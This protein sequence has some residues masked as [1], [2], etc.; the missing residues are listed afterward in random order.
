MLTGFA[1]ITALSN[2]AIQTVVTDVHRAR[3][4]Y[5]EKM[6]LLSIWEATPP[7]NKYFILGHYIH[8]TNDR[9]NSTIQLIVARLV[10][11]GYF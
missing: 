6:S 3:R 2:G 11:M 10:R 5:T 8:F 9:V 7:T 4:V 1:V